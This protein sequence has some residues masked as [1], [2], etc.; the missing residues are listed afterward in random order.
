MTKTLIAAGL[1]CSTLL[2]SAA[3]AQSQPQQ[4]L[5]STDAGQANTGFITQGALG[6]LRA[7]DLIGEDVVG[8]NNEEVGEIEDIILDRSGRVVGFVID[9]EDG[10]GIGERE[11]A[12][13]LQALQV[14]PVDS[15][16]STGTIPSAGLPASTQEG[17]QARDQNRIGRVLTPERI[18]LTIP[19]DQL[20]SAPA[21]AGSDDD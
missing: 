13:P 12:V 21:F 2:A 1:L 5:G 17:Q 16:V 18:I 8:A 3:L 20:R 9:M 15:T 7:S 6:G 10:P 4:P 14:D 19:T 11:I